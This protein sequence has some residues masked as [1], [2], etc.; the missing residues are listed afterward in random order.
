MTRVP[1]DTFPVN[2]VQRS[3]RWFQRLLPRGV[4]VRA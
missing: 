4:V 3:L 2:Q 1:V